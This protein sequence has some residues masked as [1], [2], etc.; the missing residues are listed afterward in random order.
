MESLNQILTIQDQ[1][2]V[3]QIISTLSLQRDFDFFKAA[4]EKGVDPSSPL[5][6]RIQSTLLAKNYLKQRSIDTKLFNYNQFNKQD[7][8][9][10]TLVFQQL[11]TALEDVPTAPQLLAVL[12]EADS[13][14]KGGKPLHAEIITQ[15]LETCTINSYKVLQI[16]F[17]DSSFSSVQTLVF[18]HR[19]ILEKIFGAIQTVSD[20]PFIFS[21]FRI[22]EKLVKNL[23]HLC[24]EVIKVVLSMLTS[25][26]SQ[27]QGGSKLIGSM[28]DIFVE[29]NRVKQSIIVSYLSDIYSNLSSI[30][31]EYLQGKDY[32]VQISKIIYFFVQMD[33]CNYQLNWDLSEKV[34]VPI[35]LNQ[36]SDQQLIAQSFDCLLQFTQHTYIASTEQDM[37]IV[38]FLSLVQQLLQLISV[39]I[40]GN[41]LVLAAALMPLFYHDQAQ[42]LLQQVL[43]IIFP[44]L[45]Q[46]IKQQNLLLLNSTG[47]LF[48]KN[49]LNF[50]PVQYFQS[51]AEPLY[52]MLEF[53]LNQI[54]MVI[55]PIIFFQAIAY[56]FEKLYLSQNASFSQLYGELQMKI[57]MVLSQSIITG[58]SIA[59]E[60]CQAFMQID[61]CQF[62]F[63]TNQ[64][65]VLS[66]NQSDVTLEAT[67]FAPSEIII[68]KQLIDILKEKL[69]VKLTSKQAVIPSLQAM[70]SFTTNFFNLLTTLN[71]QNNK[72]Q[73]FLF[74][75]ESCLSNLVALLQSLT[76][77]MLNYDIF[78]LEI[79][80]QI[81]I[82]DII[83]LYN[84]NLKNLLEFFQIDILNYHD[85]ICQVYNAYTRIAQI[86]FIKNLDYI[87][88]LIF[89]LEILFNS[90]RNSEYLIHVHACELLANLLPLVSNDVAAQLYNDAVLQLS[91]DLLP[92]SRAMLSCMC[93]SYI[94][95]PNVVNE[96]VQKQILNII[97][98]NATYLNSAVADSKTTELCITSMQLS[99]V[100][101]TL[102]NIIVKQHD[103]TEILKCFYSYLQNV[104]L[105]FDLKGMGLAIEFQMLY[106]AI[107]CSQNIRNV[108]VQPDVHK[109][110]KES[111]S[112]A[113]SNQEEMIQNVLHVFMQDYNLVM[114]GKK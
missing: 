107:N 78:D 75:E 18:K 92:S 79:Q 17:E 112:I 61:F 76:Q 65:Y 8:A 93:Q 52:L 98:K 45:Q 23:P 3:N 25:Y 62:F 77:G 80:N 95:R 44:F 94:E 15:L 96:Q 64:K 66:E 12:L 111:I 88:N 30:Y 4:L 109:I 105:N 108:L 1:H 40:T 22:I 81:S 57:L 19:T 28:L 110:V 86:I 35:I 68:K 103:M 48:I 55:S 32:G 58:S 84:Q 49:F 114:Q 46:E 73:L 63:S 70:N 101:F 11:L 31:L 42:P 10:R 59:S 21:C 100:Y 104:D 2:R 33:K 54:D 113:S 39:S 90:S 38:P 34:I 26:I 43:Q 20:E 56:Y 9:Y 91:K 74:F 82:L 5:N 106:G 97:L 99:G 51:I 47:I 72:N 14:T 102:P 7:K 67:K 85:C 41:Y 29:I 37:S 36:K 60:L 69:T 6:E 71:Q 89:L 16:L 13:L 27:G 83:N 53:I 50:V 87:D 24:E